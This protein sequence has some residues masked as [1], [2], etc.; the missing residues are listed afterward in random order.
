MKKT[1]LTLVSIIAFAFSSLAQNVN[2]PDANFK[3]YLLGNALI[4]TD[5]DKLEISVAEANQFHGLCTRC[6]VFNWH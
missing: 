6:K 4:N 5:A 2:I 1:L 3:K